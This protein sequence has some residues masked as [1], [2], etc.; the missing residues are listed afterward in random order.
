[1]F[2]FEFFPWVFHVFVF[3]LFAPFLSVFFVFTWEEISLIESNQQIYDFYSQ[4]IIKK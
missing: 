2:E 1:M 4:V 3:C